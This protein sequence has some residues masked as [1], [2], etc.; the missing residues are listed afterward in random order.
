MIA[1]ANKACISWE[2]RG[3]RGSYF[4]KQKFINMNKGEL[5]IKILKSEL[6]L[7][8]RFENLED[9]KSILEDKRDDIL[10]KGSKHLRES[11]NIDITYGVEIISNSIDEFLEFV[12]TNL[13]RSKELYN[14][15]VDVK[16][17]IQND[18]P[19]EEDLRICRDQI[20]ELLDDREVYNSGC[21]NMRKFFKKIGLV[22]KYKRELEGDNI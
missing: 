16:C 17:K 8:M 20:K 4:P 1:K 2:P 7:R 14:M 21:Q 13:D 18:E 11:Q 10:L 3:T 22:H 9:I 6:F 12:D 5:I 19:Y 15:L